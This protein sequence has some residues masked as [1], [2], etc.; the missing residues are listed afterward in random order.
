MISGLLIVAM[1]TA[2]F[3]MVARRLSGTMLTAP[4]IFLGL[5]FL[6][7]LTELMPRAE[8]EGILHLVAE[9]ALVVILFLDA[10]QPT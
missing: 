6:L 8:V 4:M 2:A 10:A 1:F 9:I 5:G 7:S 3:T